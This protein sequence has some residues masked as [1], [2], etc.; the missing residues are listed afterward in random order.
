MEHYMYIKGNDTNP[1]LMKMSYHIL[2]NFHTIK[3]N[4]KDAGR[5]GAKVAHNTA[6]VRANKKG[7]LFMLLY[8]FR[9]SSRLAKAV[10]KIIQQDPENLPINLRKDWALLSFFLE[11][12]RQIRGFSMNLMSSELMER[13]EDRNGS[14]IY[15][16]KSQKTKESMGPAKIIVI[17]SQAKK[18]LNLYALRE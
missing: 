4:L 2:L 11:G 8:H 18:L 16:K 17:D 7:D 6:I 14:L 10:Q 1:I 15:S 5:E 13:V 3:A 12:Q 9:R